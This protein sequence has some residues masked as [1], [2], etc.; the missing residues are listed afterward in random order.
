MDLNH[1]TINYNQQ[2]RSL[3]F[4]KRSISRHNTYLHRV[5]Y[6]SSD[7]KCSS[8]K[9]N[10]FLF[11]CLCKLINRSICSSSCDT[12]CVFGLFDLKTIK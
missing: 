3:P 9:V 12:Y 6:E 5:K 2:F 11:E 8:S 4:D 7:R 10:S 1:F